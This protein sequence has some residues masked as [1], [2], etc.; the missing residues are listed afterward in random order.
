MKRGLL[1]VI[2]VSTL[3]LAACGEDG[4]A[5][6]G[7]H[8]SGWLAPEGG[9]EAAGGSPTPVEDPLVAAHEVEWWNLGLAEEPPPSA[10]AEVVGV[11]FGRSDGT[12]RYIQA[13]PREIA[14]ALPGVRFPALLPSTVES[15]TSQLVFEPGSAV[16]GD[17]YVAAFGLWTTE[18]YSRSRSVGQQGVLWVDHDPPIQVID[19]NATDPE[20]EPVARRTR[21][22]GGL[23]DEGSDRCT[24]RTLGDLET[25]RLAS[26]L[27]VTWIWFEDQYRYELFLRDSDD[28]LELVRAMLS[29]R[30]LLGELVGSGV[31][32]DSSG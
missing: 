3:F 11:V 31:V 1:G 26:P 4:L 30:V 15:I 8:S 10:A 9:G 5:G 24:T 29:E 6:F 19:P 27:G 28:D 25:W 17:D 21:G 22:C 20:G 16:L 13:D 12:D 18:P 23:T 32:A 14:A 7:S 2:V